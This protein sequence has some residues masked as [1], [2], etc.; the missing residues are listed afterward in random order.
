[1]PSLFSRLILSFFHGK[2]SFIGL[3]PGLLVDLGN[4]DVGG[5]QMVDISLEGVGVFYMMDR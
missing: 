3:P 2:I 5:K 4:R 1:M